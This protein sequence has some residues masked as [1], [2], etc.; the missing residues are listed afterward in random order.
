LP[1]ASLLLGG[2]PQFVAAQAVPLA[3]G[4]RVRVTHADTSWPSPQV[5]SLESVSADSVVIRS[6][7]NS[8]VALSRASVRSFEQGREAGRYT[9]R[10]AALGLLGGV[11]AAGVVVAAAARECEDICGAVLLAPYAVVGSALVGVFV[12]TAIGGAVHRIEWRPAA[13]PARLGLAPGRQ[14]AVVRLL[15]GF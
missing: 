11:I 7:T 4:V 14:G 9:G 3:P 15:L 1:L 5:G 8:R 12:G 2:A 13:L 6:A 10:G